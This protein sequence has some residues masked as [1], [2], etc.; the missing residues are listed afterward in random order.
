MS[1]QTCV[2]ITSRTIFFQEIEGELENGGIFMKL[3]IFNIYLL[4][5]PSVILAAGKLFPPSNENNRT[6]HH[7][8]GSGLV[9]MMDR[10]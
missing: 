2:S 8:R 6:V 3:D 9:K 1:L 5:V 10:C 7:R 4:G